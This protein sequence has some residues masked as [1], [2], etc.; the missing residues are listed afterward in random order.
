MPT[1][2]VDQAAELGGL[3]G[4]NQYLSGIDESQLRALGYLE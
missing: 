1:D 4:E 3:V 2:L